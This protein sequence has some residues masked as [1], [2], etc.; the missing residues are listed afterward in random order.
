MHSELILTGKTSFISD[1]TI[2]ALKTLPKTSAVAFD[3][4]RQVQY[5][6]KFAKGSS[7]GQISRENSTFTPL[8]QFF[9][10]NVL[11]EIKEQDSRNLI[12]SETLHVSQL[13]QGNYLPEHDD[14][15][16]VVMDDGSVRHVAYSCL[17]YIEPSDGGELVL[18][19]GTTQELTITPARGNYVAFAASTRHRVLPVLSGDRYAVLFRLMIEQL[20]AQPRML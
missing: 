1:E 10:D 9:E 5:E 6:P 7:S 16:D 12:V 17:L 13:V 18:K 11:P 14:I 8:W 2:L 15:G 3:P 20:P 19:P 4:V